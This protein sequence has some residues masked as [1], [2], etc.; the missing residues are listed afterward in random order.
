MPD[1]DKLHFVDIVNPA[2]PEA[3][4]M[5]FRRIPKELFEQVKDIEFN[6]DLLYR[7]P[8]SFINNVNTRFYVLT[9]D[10][11]LIKGILWAY[12]NLLT[13]KIQVNILSIEK[14]YQFSNAL[15][16]TLEFIKSWHSEDENLPIQIITTR[17]AVYEEVG[18]K[19]SKQLL[20]EIT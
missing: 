20:M 15:K 13:E 10:G 4:D 1:F 9:D 7:T 6:V 16:K 11:D 2:S 19:K 14:E 5:V 17:P 8:S 18:F 3:T 12:V